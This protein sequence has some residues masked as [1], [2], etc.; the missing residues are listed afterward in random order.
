[1]GIFSN[2]S[3]KVRLHMTSADISGSLSALN[4]AGIILHHIIYD[5]DVC[6]SFIVSAADVS[7]VRNILTKRGDACKLVQTAGLQILLNQIKKRI[8]I[9]LGL[10]LLIALT[11]WIPRRIFFVEINGNHQISN[12]SILA[13]AQSHGIRFGCV[14]SELRSENLK[15]EIIKDIPQLEWVG[16]TTRGCVA[17][18]TVSEKKPGVIIKETESLVSNVIA[19]RDGII[20]DVTAT[21]GKIL[22]KPGQAVYEGQILISGY[23]DFGLVLKGSNAEGEV[24]A[25]TFYEIQGIAPRIYQRRAEKYEINTLWSLQIGKKFINFSKDSGISP[26]SC[27]KMY[28]KRY[29]S[30]PGG[31]QLPICLIRQDIIRY[32]MEKEIQFD[33]LWMSS[34]MNSYLNSQMHAGEVISAREATERLDHIFYINSRYSCMEQIGVRKIEESLID[35]GKNS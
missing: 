11:I 8:V 30:L 31:F 19:R 29:V 18:I 10:V 5:S 21:K 15:N 28:S 17:I 34:A 27:V 7:K 24:L 14:R 1:M 25:K 12:Q 16:L 2:I 26:A 3:G 13:S 20:N 35:Y 33:N 23:E 22:C 32:H 6:C 9:L 4:R